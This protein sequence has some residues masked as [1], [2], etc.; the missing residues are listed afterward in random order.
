MFIVAQQD[1]LSNQPNGKDGTRAVD[2]GPAK[3]V[4]KPCG[5]KF[6]TNDKRTR[7]I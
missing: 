6:D 5:E 4:V 2:C 3:T 7:S 1:V